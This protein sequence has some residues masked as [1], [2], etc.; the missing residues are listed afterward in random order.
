MNIV[1]LILIIFS[2]CNTQ[3]YHWLKPDNL[4]SVE[5]D[6]DRSGS[7]AKKVTNLSSLCS[8][9]RSVFLLIMTHCY[10]SAHGSLDMPLF[11]YLYLIAIHVLL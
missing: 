10:F 1:I 9:F 5:Y 8:D 4:F 3:V 7:R 2:R 11:S 6:L